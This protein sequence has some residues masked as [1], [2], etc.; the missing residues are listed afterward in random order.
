[1]RKRRLDLKM[2]QKE[3]AGRLGTTVCTIRNWE[4]NRSN[5]SLGFIPKIVQFLG[6]VPHDTPDHDFGKKLVA[7]RRLLG[8]S[9]KGLA[10]KIGVAPCTVRSREK[11]KHKPSKPVGCQRR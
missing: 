3:V 11:G 4:K 7:K 5:P 10:C 8:L 9:Q 1:L 6:Y 2:L